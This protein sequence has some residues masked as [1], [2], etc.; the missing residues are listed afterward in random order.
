[1]L[2]RSK[3]HEIISKVTRRAAKRMN[4]NQ[5]HLVESKL[6]SRKDGNAV[7]EGICHHC[8]KELTRIGK[9]GSTIIWQCNPCSIRFRVVDPR[10]EIDKLVG[11]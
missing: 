1:M 10:D 5:V 11:R 6:L 7:M 8:R 3:M 9:E 4:S 2:S